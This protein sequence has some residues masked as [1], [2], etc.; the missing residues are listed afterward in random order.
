[1]VRAPAICCKGVHRSCFSDLLG[2]WHSTINQAAARFVG[3]FRELVETSH[4]LDQLLS[5]GATET[6]NANGAS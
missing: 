2:G 5:A 4:K 1:M 3:R 6:G